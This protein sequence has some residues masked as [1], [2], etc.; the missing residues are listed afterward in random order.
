MYRK[1]RRSSG[2]QSESKT[3][4]E[5]TEIVSQEHILWRRDKRQ[6]RKE[7][8]ALRLPFQF[9]LSPDTPPSCHFYGRKFRRSQRHEAS[10]VYHIEVVAMRSELLVGVRSASV[11][12]L[13]SWF[14]KKNHY[15]RR[16]LAVL[17]KDE[18]GALVTS[19]LELLGGAY[20]TRTREF[21]TKI[22][23]GLVGR[24]G[25]VHMEVSVHSPL[26]VSLS[27]AHCSSYAR[28]TIPS[29]S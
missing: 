7:E 5:T 3:Q 2:G 21:K 24:R 11:V 13:R 10:V 4:S 14:L 16:P 17:P 1:I 18:S 23:R 22:R 28:L 20:P 9:T 19:E 29:P 26:C 12:G 6:K 15:I 8:E 25:S 27:A